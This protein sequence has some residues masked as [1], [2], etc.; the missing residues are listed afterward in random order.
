MKKKT[1]SAA[2][3]AAN[4]TPKQVRTFVDHTRL[5]VPFKWPLVLAGVSLPQLQAWLDRARAALGTV[6]PGK[7]PTNCLLRMFWKMGEAGR[8]GKAELLAAVL[9]AAAQGDPEAKKYL[10][11]HG[12]RLRAKAA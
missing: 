6:K 2:P 4:P 9:K 8:R 3:A 12:R 10:R 11:R 7:A 5:G 1:K